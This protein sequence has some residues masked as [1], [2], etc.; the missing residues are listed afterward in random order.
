MIIGTVAGVAGGAILITVVV[1][2]LVS[3]GMTWGAIGHWALHG[4]ASEQCKLMY[5]CMQEKMVH[6]GGLRYTVFYLGDLV[7]VKNCFIT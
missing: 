7:V 5:M 3:D 1:A 6:V 4:Q 2:I